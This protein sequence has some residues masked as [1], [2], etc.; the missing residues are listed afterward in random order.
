ML[1][2]IS[3]RGII[4]FKE[5]VPRLNAAAIER[6]RQVASITGNESVKHHS[7]MS[8]NALEIGQKC[9]VAGPIVRSPEVDFPP[10]YERACL[11]RLQS[12]QDFPRKSN[13][14][15]DQIPP[16][17]ILTKLIDVP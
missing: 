11:A 1:F 17:A 6:D 7:K 14:A 16:T 10:N 3:N 13:V 8:V 4:A 2:W 12:S 9:L 5:G 15:L